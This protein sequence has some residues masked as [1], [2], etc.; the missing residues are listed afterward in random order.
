VMLKV[1]LAVEAD[2]GG[3]GRALLA[4]VDDVVE[5]A[6]RLRLLR[7]LPGRRGCEERTQPI[8]PA[9]GDAKQEMKER[10]AM[11]CKIQG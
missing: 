4:H 10:S 7:R 6:E 8:D 11:S 5:L 3:E 1:D 9:S 2:R